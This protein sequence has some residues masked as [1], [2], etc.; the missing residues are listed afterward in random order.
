M[1]RIKFAVAAILA[2][3]II[4]ATY[5]VHVF[6]AISIFLYSI[7]ALLWME[8]APQRS[9]QASDMSI[10]V[11]ELRRLKGSEQVRRRRSIFSVVFEEATSRAHVLVRALG[12]LAFRFAML[13]CSTAYLIQALNMN[14]QPILTGASS[15]PYLGIVFML[16]EYAI[17]PLNAILKTHSLGLPSATTLNLET[18]WGLT[19]RGLIYLLM[20]FLV[21]GIIRYWW[22]LIRI[23][24]NEGLDE[25]AEGATWRKRKLPQGA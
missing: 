10:P 20:A 3:G 18:W 11:D 5:N 12:A 15:Q 24:R 17:P 14:G 1:R 19:V 9:K 7:T 4:E 2:I 25:I 21:F 22:E 6:L 13:L 16:V 8:A 23:G